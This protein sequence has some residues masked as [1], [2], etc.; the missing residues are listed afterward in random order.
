MRVFELLEQ[1]RKAASF[2]AAMAK[3]RRGPF[4]GLHIGLSYG[5]GQRIPSRLNNGAHAQLLERLI[6]DSDVIRMAT[7]ASGESF[8]CDAPPAAHSPPAAFNL[9]APKIYAYYKNYNDALNNAPNEHLHF[10]PNFPK[11][12]FAC[13]TFNFGPNVWTFKHRDVLNLPFG[14]CAIQALGPFDPTKGG[15]LILWDLKLVIE[16]PPGALILLPS[17]TI[18]HSN[19]PVQP[20]DQRA[21]FTQYTA[22]GIFRFV[23]N[24]FRTESE[25]AEE[26]PEEYERICARKAGRW[27]M[28]LGLLSTV[29]ELLEPL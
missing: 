15:H 26:D 2:K 20:G 10:R 12:I 6:G 1:E 18:A 21:S 4:V 16:F 13:A 5:K 7:F 9:W 29:D 3:H 14:M 27:E 25:L 19:V 22:G 17:A 23:D 24:G 28:G 11:S 8:H